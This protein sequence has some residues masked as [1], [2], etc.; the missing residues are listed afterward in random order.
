[1]NWITPD[2][3]QLRWQMREF[4]SVKPTV[5]R[6]SNMVRGNRHGEINRRTDLL[7]NMFLRLTNSRA[8]G[9]LSPVYR[10]S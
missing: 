8:E 1:M 9:Y 10:H 6:L 7:I 5:W 2:T 4:V 3:A